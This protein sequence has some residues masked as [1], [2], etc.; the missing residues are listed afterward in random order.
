MA[1]GRF[2]IAVLFVLPTSALAQPANPSVQAPGQA[3]GQAPGHPP[4]RPPAHAPAR[5]TS[6]HPSQPAPRRP[7]AAHP[8]RPRA[9]QAPPPAPAAPPVAVVEKPAEPAKGTDT[10]LPLPRFV[11]LRADVV[12]LR[13]GPGRQYP[14]EWVYQRR[15]LPV[16]IQREFEKW[17]LVEDQDGVKGWVHQATLTARRTGVVV[18]G[19]RDLRSDGRPDASA[20]AHLKPGVV[21]RVRACAAGADWCQASVGDYR[22]WIRRTDFWG[23]L[24]NEEVT[25]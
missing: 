18:G 8:A 16:E 19:E 22:G 3:S 14:I 1:P 24:P 12:N 17:R 7:G 10:N 4:G 13:A 21:L 25:P 20:I 23:L 6:S 9:V 15:D 11:S 2:L 5:T